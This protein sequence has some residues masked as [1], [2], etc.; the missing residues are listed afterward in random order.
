MAPRAS[1]LKVRW[2]L[3]WLLLVCGGPAIAITSR[4]GVLRD[5]GGQ[6]VAN[7]QVILTADAGHWRVPHGITLNA[8]LELS[9]TDP[10]LGDYRDRDFA[11]TRQQRDYY[12]ERG[13][14][15]L[16]AEFERF[17]HIATAWPQEP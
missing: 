12:F 14:V 10:P 5:G 16:T 7:A 6:P 15:E 17:Q 2:F 11:C 13:S 3:P 4:T 8:D 1:F 9:D